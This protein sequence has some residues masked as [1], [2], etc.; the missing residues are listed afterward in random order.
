[1][2]RVS[3]G[4]A[5]AAAVF[6]A[7]LGG[8]AA[9]QSGGSVVYLPMTFGGPRGA[10]PAPNPGPS[11]PQ[12]LFHQPGQ[13]I[14]G[15]SLAIDA[16]GGTHLAYR[17]I[18][19]LEQQPALIYSYCAPNAACTSNTAWS[20]LTI[21]GTVDEVQL[22]LTPAGQPRVLVGLRQK[23]GNFE[24]LYAYG[25]CNANC[26][27]ETQWSFALVTSRLDSGIGG[28]T[29]AY[30]PVRSFALD[31]AG[32]PRFVLYDANYVVEPDHYGGFY[33]SCDT[34]CTNQGQWSEARFTRQRRLSE[35]NIKDEVIN[36][37]VLTFT[38]DG[39]PRILAQLFPL[40]G[41]GTAGLT[42]FACDAGCDDDANWERTF[43]VERG[44][45]PYPAWDLALDASNRPR[46]AY[47]RYDA[48]DDTEQKLF[49]LWCDT[50]CTSGDNW[51]GTDIGMPKGDG[52]GADLEL[53]AQN[54][55]RIAY[56][57]S[58]ALGYAFCNGD[59]SGPGGWQRRILD[60]H[61]ALEAAYPIP[62]PFTCDSG[63][64]D[65]Y[66]PSFRLD[67]AGNPR[68]AYDSSYKAGCLYSDPA[69]PAKPPTREFRE[70]RR[71]VRMVF[72]TP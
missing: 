51:N 58:N 34:N 27:Q 69:N 62:L 65:S 8:N 20:R 53:D 72:A 37:P 39:K 59:C 12:A 32:R 4:G 13:S 35:Y 54:R 52:I 46:V 60:T 19:P 30:L 6:L 17:E 3:W 50:G 64:W 41:E 7:L 67:R 29:G 47:F 18:E 31:P 56:L 14:G 49:Y 48:S 61:A 66:A 70:I 25:E 15:A 10:A 40:D 55:P 21:P 68:I 2:R 16:A 71:S 63:I 36:A 38:S 1:M 23:S 57:N 26:Q 45:G 44:S 43:L 11:G 42:Y 28:V 5:L 33:F 24:Q 9:A 22:R